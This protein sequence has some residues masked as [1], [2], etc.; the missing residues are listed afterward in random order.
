MKFKRGYPRQDKG[1][2]YGTPKRI[3]A[4]HGREYESVPS[5]TK[6]WPCK[7]LKGDHQ[8]SE[9][10]P[11][12]LVFDNKKIVSKDMSVQYC[13]GCNKK[14]YIFTAFGDK[15][16][17]LPNGFYKRMRYVHVRGKSSGQHE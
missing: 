3:Q 4:E 7:K 16:E 9:P 10:E 11:H 13:N 12:V 6:H 1:I 15:Y 5:K 8:W 17:R 14:N 2:H